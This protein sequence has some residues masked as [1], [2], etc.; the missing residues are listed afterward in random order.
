MQKASKMHWEIL[1]IN[2]DLTL[3]FRFLDGIKTANQLRLQFNCK[4]DQ[5]LIKC[6]DFLFY[7]NLANRSKISII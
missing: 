1:I 6:T 7:I 2:R 3:L 5:K 4:P